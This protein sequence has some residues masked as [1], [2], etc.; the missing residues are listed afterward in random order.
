MLHLINDRAPVLHNVRRILKPGG[1]FISKTICL[2][3][4]YPLAIPFLKAAVFVM[5]TAGKAPSVAFISARQLEREI[6]AAGFTIVESAY[7]ASKGKPIRP[8]IVARK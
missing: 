6:E 2:A 1:Y 8:F 7:H 3:D 5:Q 4:L